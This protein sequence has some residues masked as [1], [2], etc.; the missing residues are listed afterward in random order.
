VLS[1]AQLIKELD[2]P[3]IAEPAKLDSK[4]KS[5]IN[6]HLSAGDLVVCLSGGGGGSLDEWLRQQF[7][8]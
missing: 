2:N 4:L 5:N 6:Q 8:K 7:K 3:K 1:P